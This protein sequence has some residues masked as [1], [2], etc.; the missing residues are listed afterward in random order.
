MKK[1]L[2]LAL[3]LGLSIAACDTTDPGN[4]DN[5]LLSFTILLSANC[6]GKIGFAD[7]FFDDRNVG[8][9]V[10]GSS[11]TID[12]TAGQHT[13]EALGNNGSRFGP[14]ERVI[15][16]SGGTQTLTCT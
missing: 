11:T 13:I 2:L 4:D 14:I 9:L 8:Q 3:F 6:E 5:G 1:N 10:P 12:T 15:E 7:V 16:F